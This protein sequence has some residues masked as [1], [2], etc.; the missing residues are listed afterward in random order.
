MN[1]RASFGVR[2]FNS[3]LLYVLWDVCDTPVRGP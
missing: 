2:L 1:V 3:E